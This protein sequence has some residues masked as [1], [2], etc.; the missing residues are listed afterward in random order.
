M[1]PT[2][3]QCGQG[4]IPTR[5]HQ[6]YCSHKCYCLS[7]QIRIEKPCGYCGKIMLI[8]PKVAKRKKY[9]SRECS[10]KARA[11]TPNPKQIRCPACGNFFIPNRNKP[12]KHCSQDCYV[13]LKLIE[14]TRA[15][16]HCNK[17]FETYNR[18]KRFCCK[19][20]GKEYR[21]ARSHVEKNCEVCNRPFLV[22]RSDKKAKY[23][24]KKCMNIGNAKFGSSNPN[25]RGGG[26]YER[27]PNWQEQANKAR[28]RDN[29]KCL[30]CNK[31][32]SSRKLHA[33]HVVPYR[34]FNGDYLK[35]NQ[36]NNLV[37]LCQRC[38]NKVEHGKMVCPKPTAN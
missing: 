21:K 17:A 12:E 6:K 19:Q 9:C 7:R 28:K 31:V 29:Y 1:V 23:C 24:S 27:G 13:Q 15:C 18:Q 37:S 33:H 4:Y 3:Q 11:K 8:I 30:G 20:C 2:C 32:Q 14:R 10:N 16:L 36:L 38:H 5:T 34:N 35:A 26:G 25:W 22:P